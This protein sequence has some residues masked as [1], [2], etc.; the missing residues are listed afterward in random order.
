MTHQEEKTRVILERLV[1]EP[2]TIIV[3]AIAIL[4]CQRAL[5]PTIFSALLHPIAGVGRLGRICGRVGHAAGARQF[6]VGAIA[7]ARARRWHTL[8]RKDTHIITDKAGGAVIAH[9][10]GLTAKASISQGHA[11]RL[12]TQ[13]VIVGDAG[14]A[15]AG[16]IRNTLKVIDLGITVGAAVHLALSLPTEDSARGLHR[17]GITRRATGVTGAAMIEEG[18]DPARLE[19]LV[20]I[21]IAIV[22]LEVTHL[23]F[24]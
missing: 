12:E 6:G 16:D 2:V 20:Y 13:T 8:V 9:I 22:I 7:A 23:F 24:R 5:A 10:A 21:T 14:L 1:G 11:G 4:G 15:N 3:H 18:I 19:G 17:V